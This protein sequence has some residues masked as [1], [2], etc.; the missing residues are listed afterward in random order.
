MTSSLLL[1][2][3]VLLLFQTHAQGAILLSDGDIPALASSSPP[4]D[5][6]NGLES[7]HVVKIPL[8]DEHR[9]GPQTAESIHTWSVLS[10]TAQTNESTHYESLRTNQ[11]AKRKLHGRFLHLTDL[12][13][14]EFYK[15]NSAVGQFCHRK[16]KKKKGEDEDEKAGWFGV[17]FSDCDSPFTLVNLTLDHLHQEWS[18]N[19]DFV[20]CEFLDFC[21]LLIAD[22]CRDG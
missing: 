19:I 8:E 12:H 5:N 20:I 15:Y 22:F 13:P 7:L 2:L 9:E 21:T 11:L 10:H 1:S 18:N 16:E 14:D 3:F 4:N 6:Q 17:P